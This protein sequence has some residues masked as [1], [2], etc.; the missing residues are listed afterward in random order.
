ML[1]YILDVINGNDNDKDDGYNFLSWGFN[2]M[3][4]LAVYILFDR[5]LEGH[6]SNNLRISP[7][8]PFILIL[9]DEKKFQRPSGRFHITSRF[10]Q[11]LHIMSSGN[12]IKSR[13][14][15]ARESIIMI[16]IIRTNDEWALCAAI[17]KDS[18]K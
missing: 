18:N 11:H 16:L 6:T 14:G 3:T 2:S 15:H 5:S 10:P 17:K 13:E 12:D 7:P 4:E 8:H 1:Y 9:I